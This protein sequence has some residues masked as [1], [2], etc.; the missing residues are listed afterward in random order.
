MSRRRSVQDAVR[1]VINQNPYLYRGVRMRVVN[2][3]AL[4]RYIHNEVETIAGENIDPNTIVTAIMRFSN[5]ST[6]VT[7]SEPQGIFHGSRLNLETG[8]SEV[9]VQSTQ[10]EQPLLLEKLASMQSAGIQFRIHQF[11]TSV[12]LTVH[13]E[14]LNEL[15]PHLEEYDVSSTGGLAE[16]NLRLQSNVRN[17]DRIA[18][19]SDLMFRNGVHMVDA[20]YSPHE[21]NLI[22]RDE[23]ASKAF[24]VLRAQIS[25]SD[26][27]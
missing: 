17:V 13:T 19:I 21:I 16:L 2:Y 10:N 15:R 18:L 7:P 27:F 14:Y 8:I 12:K 6:R 9:T 4:A 26:R 24:E 25:L 22:L 1:I 11:P 23:D 5:E 20:F 3:S